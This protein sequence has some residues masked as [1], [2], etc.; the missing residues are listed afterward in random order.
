MSNILIGSNAIKHHFSDFPREP[1][2]IDYIE[3][4]DVSEGVNDG[5][6]EG[7]KRVEYHTNP[8]FKN[9]NHTVMLPNDLY[10]L[11]VSH[12]IG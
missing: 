1:N 9:Y 2:D 7:V 5:V 12:V 3:N 10:T 4:D 11:K 8:V 6:S